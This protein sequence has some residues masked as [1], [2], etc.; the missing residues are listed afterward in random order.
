MCTPIPT[1]S[2]MMQVMKRNSLGGGVLS[3]LQQGFR[4]LEELGKLDNMLKVSI[5]TD[6]AHC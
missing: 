1:G 4:K 6:S 2:E 5:A 3:T